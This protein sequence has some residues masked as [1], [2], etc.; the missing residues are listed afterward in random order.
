MSTQEPNINLYETDAGYEVDVFLP[1]VR[2]EDIELSVDQ[3]TLSVRAEAKSLSPRSGRPSKALTQEMQSEPF[4][5]TITFSRPI[6]TNNI[7]T[8]FQ[9]GILTILLLVDERSRPK[10]ISITGSQSQQQQSQHQSQQ[11]QSQRQS[12]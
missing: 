5:R 3:N 7:Q 1:G 9:N 11:Q 6:D 12:Q 10:R 8:Q 4:E 2:P